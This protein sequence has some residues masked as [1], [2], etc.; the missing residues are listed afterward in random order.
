LEKTIAKQISKASHQYMREFAKQH[1]KVV[2]DNRRLLKNFDELKSD[3]R[4]LY[5]QLAFFQEREKLGLLREQ[6][7]IKR[8]RDLENRFSFMLLAQSKSREI[9]YHGAQPSAI[10]IERIK[11]AQPVAET[12]DEPETLAVDSA[13]I[14]HNPIA[15]AGDHMSERPTD[16]A[17]NHDAS[18]ATGSETTVSDRQPETETAAVSDT[19][20]Q[21]EGA[22]TDK[23]LHATTTDAVA[24]MPPSKQN[25]TS[26]NAA[27]QE[28][29]EAIETDPDDKKAILEF[30]PVFDPVNDYL[31]MGIAASKRNE[32]HSAIECFKKVSVLAPK[33]QRSFYNL[34]V[35]YYRRKDYKN[36]GHYA[37]QALALGADGAERIIK[38]IEAQKAARIDDLSEVPENTQT[39][40][41][42]EDFIDV[43]PADGTV[44]HGP[45]EIEEAPQD[46]SAPQEAPGSSANQLAADTDE[47]VEQ[48][49]ATGA[50]DL[51]P[52][53]PVKASAEVSEDIAEVV[54][55]HPAKAESAEV[56]QANQVPAPETVTPVEAA[57]DLE[58]DN[59]TE[60]SRSEEAPVDMQQ[61]PTTEP[62][63]PAPEEE[64]MSVE[65]STPPGEEK[66]QERAI[67]APD[68]VAAGESAPEPEV[69]IDHFTLAMEAS[70]RKDYAEAIVHFNKSIEQASDKSRVY[71][72]LAILHYRLKDYSAA[73]TWAKQAV[74]LGV[75]AAGRI[76]QKAERKLARTTAGATAGADN[77]QTETVVAGGESTPIDMPGDGHQERMRK[78]EVQPPSQPAADK[79]TKEPM[80]EDAMEITEADLIAISPEQAQIAAEDTQASPDFPTQDGEF[81]ESA[82]PG[83]TSRKI[84]NSDI[85]KGHP[86]KK[87]IARDDASAKAAGER[88]TEPPSPVESAQAEPPP[89]TPS[90]PDDTPE[91]FGPG[92]SDAMPDAGA[93]KQTAAPEDTTAGATPSPETKAKEP[94]VDYFELAMAASERKD[95]SEAIVQLNKF[96]EQAP[97]ESRGYYNLAI[98]HYRLKDYQ[99][100]ID[101][102]NR[103][104]E[105]G[106]GG[107]KR[108]VEKAEKILARG[109][110]ST[111]KTAAEKPTA[112]ANPGPDKTEPDMISDDQIGAAAPN[113]NPPQKLPVGA[114]PPLPEVVAEIEL[115]QS[116]PDAHM[117]GKDNAKTT[118][119]SQAPT[120]EIEEVSEL[121]AHEE[122]RAN[123]AQT[124]SSQ[125]IEAASQHDSGADFEDENAFESSRPV[126]KNEA[127]QPPDNDPGT[128]VPQ[129]PNSAAETAG[130]GDI[131][132][133]AE[134]GAAL[135]QTP[136]EAFSVEDPAEQAAKDY[137]ALG[138]EAYARKDYG[139]AI[140]LFNLFIER[141][142]DEPR[143]YYNL[144]ILHYRL[145]DYDAAESNAK[146]A[147]KLGAQA[148]RR[149]LNKV[150]KIRAAATK[151]IGSKLPPAGSEPELPPDTAGDKTKA[152]VSPAAQVQPADKQGPAKDHRDEMSENIDEPSTTTIS[153]S[154]AL[155]ADT[156]VW[157]ADELEEAGPI[158]NTAAEGDQGSGVQDDVIL[159]DRSETEASAMDPAFPFEEESDQTDLTDELITPPTPAASTVEDDTAQEE[160]LP[161]AGTEESDI[162]D[163]EAGEY[164]ALGLAASD[165]REY[166]KAIQYFTKFTN[167]APEDPRGFY[168][169]AVVSYRLKFYETAHEH[170]KHALELGSAPAN[171]L[172]GKIE[173]Q[174]AAT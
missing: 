122:K 41:R 8:I 79:S 94:S 55:I 5:E 106:A 51:S 26:K 74:D 40:L 70:E 22:N 142:P 123:A 145:K 65:S 149:I 140:E 116:L 157:D 168:N 90:R 141:Y 120:A 154:E 15:D 13:K 36:A 147:I 2:A 32:Y 133:Q 44:S 102:A 11:E 144:A 21:P 86:A 48:P 153:I 50:A 101:C 134:P 121:E 19:D 114:S 77:A 53:A 9:P 78:T 63:D 43:S 93:D 81:A 17:L 56:E 37:K 62:M 148:A 66:A 46:L 130:P 128:T 83:Q 45:N 170:A 23:S 82:D 173:A 165:Q 57:Q 125:E 3:Y 151:P 59:R 96:V 49:G 150:E 30:D 95:Y 108:I 73:L 64:K 18:V 100:A 16:D 42:L 159:F 169:L 158:E 104:G 6:Q 132:G 27:P 25:S 4:F 143:G 39:V 136:Q 87:A 103:A 166:L 24:A 88:G 68:S 172:I 14:Q 71:Y 113:E 72:N 156:V 58:K 34:A 129:D 85:E 99:K 38:T 105:L 162:D 155:G 115:P 10:E 174:L 98:L 109:T 67:P 118:P 75:E 167:M 35:I 29:A 152:A 110:E 47:I 146:S 31:A 107:A 137:F 119:D 92:R 60:Q 111:P 126:V 161:A 76:V 20:N 1:K 69:P 138:Q 135:P 80:P 54:E 52:G 112:T 84:A 33:D 171:R 160:S 131:S 91:N 139:E 12:G 117:A 7:D 61:T 164:F 163:D 97:D 89:E 124:A 28:A 127:E